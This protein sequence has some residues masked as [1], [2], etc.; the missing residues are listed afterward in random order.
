VPDGVLL[1]MVKYPP[2]APTEVAE[3]FHTAMRKL[4][5]DLGATKIEYNVTGYLANMFYIRT[6]HEKAKA[7]ILGSMA[8]EPFEVQFH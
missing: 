4:N 2:K 6:E 3:R 5:A 8:K 1:C 7:A